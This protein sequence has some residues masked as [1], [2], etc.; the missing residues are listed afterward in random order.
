MIVMKFGGSSIKNAE[1]IK[2]VFSIINKRTENKEIIIV[3]SA[4][5]GVTNRLK[6]LAENS[7]SNIDIN[8]NLNRLKKTHDDCY[9]QLLKKKPNEVL[10]KLYSNLSEDLK[11]IKSSGVLNPKDLD[12]VLSY[13]EIL[14]TR[15]ISDYFTQKGIL[16]ETLITTDVI[17]TDNCFGNAYVHYQKS[18]DNIRNYLK[19]RTKLQIVTGFIGA[20]KEGETTTLGRNGSDYTASIIGAAINAKDIEIWSDVDGVLSTNP[21]ITKS[22]K[23]ISELSYEEAME[24]AHAGAEVLFP[25]S[26]IPALYKNIPIKIRNTFNQNQNGTNINQKRI[27]KEAIVGIS[28][29][30]KISLI[31]LQGA[32]L[33]DKKGTIGRMFSCLAS[34]RINIKLIAQTFSEHS[35]CFAINPKWNKK[36]KTALESEFSFEIKENYMDKIII[37]DELSMIAVVGEGMRNKPG[38]AGN[39]FSTLGRAGINIVAITQVN[40]QLNISFIVQDKDVNH[41]IKVLHERLFIHK[42]K[43][44]IFLIGFGLVGKSLISLINKDKS[45]SLC[46][47]MNSKTM[48]IDELGINIS[49]IS[50]SLREGKSYNLDNFIKSALNTPNAIIVDATSSDHI[51]EKTP[52]L[53]KSGISVVTASKLANSK[54][55]NFYDSIRTFSIKSKFK[56]EANVGA[57]LPIIETLR[58]LLKTG[59]KII[60]IEGIMSG[61]LSFLFSNYNGSKTFSKLVTEARNKGFTEPDPRDDLNGI[62]VGRK[63]LILARET[64]AKLELNDVSIESLIPDT[65]DDNIGVD[66]FLKKLSDFD[67]QFLR[68]YQKANKQNQV[69]RYIASW[70]G[71]KAEV[72]LKAVNIEDQFYHQ[73]GRENFIVFKT[74]RYNEIPLV[75][76]GHG[77]GAEVTAAAVLGDILSC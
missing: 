73:S 61:T 1:S 63:I 33:I 17:L 59:D 52:E 42:N 64:G 76:K 11:S 29:L 77:A 54:N 68:K 46:G 40:S 27:K 47:L 2:E 14:S 3:F 43:K 38:V 28:C 74:E 45:I 15:I 22:A 13:G 10:V 36:A 51:A 37:E 18:F 55:Q 39:I 67:D 6:A 31:R 16:S 8:H 75:I 21:K 70:D 25:P 32:G 20:T 57:G 35:I 44:N 66:D 53:I 9:Y 58:T 48:I 24:L 50:K 56:Y 69:L 23:V 65:I 49:S 71:M 41:A 7:A 12:K 26:I 72:K 34:A 4:M 62:D 30:E 60:K 19:N 5:K